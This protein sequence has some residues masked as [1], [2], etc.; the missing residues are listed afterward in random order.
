MSPT[1]DNQLFAG[2]TAIAVFRWL[3]QRRAFIAAVVV[4]QL[5]WHG[6]CTAQDQQPTYPVTGVVENSVT[7]QPIARALVEAPHDAVLTDNEGRFELHLPAGQEMIS[8]RRPGYA[9]WRP[10]LGNQKSITV[11][12][13]MVPLTLSLTP[14]TIVSGHVALDGGDDPTGIQLTL[15]EKVFSEGRAQWQQTGVVTA[16]SDGSFQ[17]VLHNA[18]GAYILCSMPSSDH[19]GP[20]LPGI[21]AWGYAPA[22]FPGGADVTSA[23]AAPLKVAAGQQLQLEIGLQRQPFFPVSISVASNNLVNNGNLQVYD[24]SGRQAGFAVRRRGQSYE[25]NLPNGRYYAES[26]SWSQN[27]HVYGRTDFTVSGAP[28]SNIQVVPVPVKPITVEVREEFTSTPA[29]GNGQIQIIDGAQSDEP[30]VGIAL[31]SL[32]GPLSGQIGASLEHP[33]G[34]PEGSYWLGVWRTGTYRLDVQDFGQVYASSVTSGSADLTKE[35]LVIG[36]GGSCPPIEITLRNDVGYLRGKLRAEPQT[37]SVSSAAPQVRPAIF[38]VISLARHRIYPAIG[39]W[40]AIAAGNTGGLDGSVPLPPGDYLVLPFANNQQ[41]DMDDQDAMS[42]LA[43]TGQTV[44]ILP[45]ATVEIEVDPAAADG[46]GGQ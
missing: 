27:L 2:I 6:R 16:G 12:D 41:I 18:P 39:G 8:A 33:Q 10:G 35:P 37:A 26:A 36:P 40:P 15:Y 1:T 45:G 46:G 3:A 30:P 43:S 42:R 24:Y 20:S 31:T 28:R 7:H 32:D 21:T 17:T 34:A 13:G 5:L 11:S 4:A 23:M 14:E 9:D 25:V 22:C 29:S 44:T 38:L 19:F